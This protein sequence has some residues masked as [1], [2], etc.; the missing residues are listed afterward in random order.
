MVRILGRTMRI[1]YP[2]I[3]DMTDALN[4][5]KD[6]IEKIEDIHIIEITHSLIA[7]SDKYEEYEYDSISEAIKE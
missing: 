6:I 1:R 2:S 7:I 3:L 4:Q 5:L